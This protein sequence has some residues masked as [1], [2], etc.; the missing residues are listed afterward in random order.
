MRA[1]AVAADAGG[2][3]IYIIINVGKDQTIRE[4]SL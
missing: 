2:P 1:N 3:R 4:V